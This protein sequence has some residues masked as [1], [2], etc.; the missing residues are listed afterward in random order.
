MIPRASALFEGKVFHARSTPHPHSFTYGLYLLYLDLEELAEL[1]L[2]PWFGLEKFRPL[3]FRRRDYLGGVGDLKTSVLD[4]VE[5]ALGKRPAGPV[6]MLTQLRTL[7]YVFNPVTFYYCFAPDG[8]NLEAVAAEITNTPWKERHT[9]VLAAEGKGARGEFQKAFHVSPFQPMAQRY[10][11]AFTAPGETLKVDMVNEQEGRDVFR[12]GLKVQ[13]KPLTSSALASVFFRY[14]L[15]GWKVPV[16]IYF[17]ALR[18][19]LKREPFYDHPQF[20]ERR[21]HHVIH[22]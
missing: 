16:A 1:S 5:S 14:P 13:R 4:R 12:A 6:R 15:M 7:G 3:S 11:W 22:P 10:R 2:G 17:Q 8:E 21:K 9:Y 20:E 19:W 18:L